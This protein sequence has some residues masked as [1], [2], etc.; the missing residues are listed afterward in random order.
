M[1]FAN[2]S[3]LAGLML[4]SALP[5]A[6]QTQTAQTQTV[7]TQAARPV[8]GLIARLKTP[9]DTAVL[10]VAHRGCWHDTAE[11]SI[12][13][14]EACIRMGVDMVELD[15]R[16][17][18]DGH[19]VLMHDSRVDRMT[20]GQGEVGDLTLADIRALRLKAGKGGKD[21]PL[22]ELRVPTFEEAML[23]A[24]GRI[25][26]NLDA[27]ADVYD[28]AFKVLQATGTGD[29][30]LMKKRVVATDVPLK[31]QVPFDRVLSMAIVDQA[32]GTAAALLVPQAA[33]PPEGFEVI[34]TD[35]AFLKAAA[36]RT[37][38][39]KA[40][41]WVNTLQPVHAAGLTDDKALNDP[42]AVWGVL[43]GEGVDALQTDEPEALLR[44]LKGIGRH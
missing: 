33:T 43:I 34:F 11:N 37:K 35:M 3:V 16:R 39:M 13:G 30:I 5:V 1:K 18:K 42:A 10:V 24:K 12:A 4:L 44:Y 22:T 9:G 27:K 7:Q 15:V 40:R 29:H 26:V 6:A 19:L 41:L 8:D 36:P 2:V 21:A 31:V 20:N 28:D 17:T 32:A 38:A 25:L 14:I 23:A